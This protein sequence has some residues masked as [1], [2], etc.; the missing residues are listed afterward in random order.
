MSGVIQPNLTVL[1]TFGGFNL[2]LHFLFLHAGTSPGQGKGPRDVLGDNASLRE[3]SRRGGKWPADCKRMSASLSPRQTLQACLKRKERPELINQVQRNRLK[4]PQGQ[5]DCIQAHTSSLSSK[6]N[7]KA[8]Y[9]R[10]IAVWIIHSIP[11]KSHMNIKVKKSSITCLSLASMTWNF[12]KAVGQC[13]HFKNICSLNL[14]CRL[15]DEFRSASTNWNT[16]VCKHLI[17]GGIYSSFHS[18]SISCAPSC[19]TTSKHNGSTAML[20]LARCSSLQRLH[21]FFIQTY[22]L[23][24]WPKTYILVSPVQSTF[25]ILHTLVLRSLFLATMPCRSL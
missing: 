22:I 10:N 19:H 14:V 6:P 5:E 9:S 2:H 21:P 23:W 1:Q 20:Q 4:E 24:L 18:H 8:H 3:S 12:Q 25:S 11:V 16:V 17:F 7:F 13:T 15:E